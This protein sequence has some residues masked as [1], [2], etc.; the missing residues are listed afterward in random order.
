MQVW[1]YAKCLQHL[2]QQ[3]RAGDGGTGMAAEDEVDETG[4]DPED[5]EES[6]A[7]DDAEGSVRAPSAASG[8][9]AGKAR[10]GGVSSFGGIG[11]GN[12]KKLLAQLLTAVATF[13]LPT[14]AQL[15]RLDPEYEG[16]PLAPSSFRLDSHG[17]FAA[18]VWS[19]RIMCVYDIYTLLILAVLQKPQTRLQGSAA[20]A[21]QQTMNVVQ[22]TIF[23]AFPCRAVPS[24]GAVDYRFGPLCFHPSAQLVLLTVLRH[25]SVP[26]TSLDGSEFLRMPLPPLVYA[27]SLRVHQPILSAVGCY[28]VGSDLSALGYGAGS[29][30]H[31]VNWRPQSFDCTPHT[32]LLALSFQ[33]SAGAGSFGSDAP[34]VEDITAESPSAAWLASAAAQDEAEAS[35]DRSARR[36]TSSVIAVYGLSPAWLL[37]AGLAHFTAPI[38]SPLPVSPDCYVHGEGALS[39]TASYA[40]RASNPTAGSAVAATS[41]KAI[42]LVD[43]STQAAGASG[44]AA[45]EGASSREISDCYPLLLALRPAFEN[46]DGKAAL[47][48]LCTKSFSILSC[49]EHVFLHRWPG[50]QCRDTKLSPLPY[51]LG[52]S[53]VH[54]GGGWEERGRELCVLHWEG[55]FCLDRRRPGRCSRARSEPLP[56]AGGAPPDSHGLGQPV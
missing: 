55:S 38:N 21:G 32:G 17:R 20:T 26:R 22:L 13:A 18:V 42:S 45:G 29:T 51:P 54:T 8:A 47:A 15:M 9:V 2:Q 53:L 24:A 49:P 41:L 16:M 6:A 5:A 35:A 27:V 36:R 28:E 14:N 48:P 19:E 11:R 30:N 25:R 10:V 44:G 52:V 56:P 3:Q 12:A 40:L 23:G 1:S 46:A 33:T 7:G 37:G 50:R 43:R 39:S 34:P 4:E 31:S